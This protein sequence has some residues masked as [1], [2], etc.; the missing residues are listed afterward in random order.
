[1]L[2]DTLVLLFGNLENYMGVI[3][4]SHLQKMRRINLNCMSLNFFLQKKSSISLRL[5]VSSFCCSGNDFN[6]V[7]IVNVIFIKFFKNK[8]SAK[9]RRRINVSKLVS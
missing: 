4:F 1:M 9:R 5:W 6:K 3:S 8:L 2:S 7:M